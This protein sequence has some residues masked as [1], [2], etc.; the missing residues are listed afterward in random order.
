VA[1]KA[2]LAVQ[3]DVT[4]DP[5]VRRQIDWLTSAG[6]T[7]D[8]LGYGDHP[9]P[10]VREHF[11]VQRPHGWQKSY[12][13]AALAHVFLPYG[14]RFKALTQ[15]RFP[16]KVSQQVA[17]GEY[18]LVI[19]NDYHF[20]PWLHDRSVF[21][22]DRKVAHVHIDLHEYFPRDL[23]KIVTGWQL[24]RPY[25]RWVR[26]FIN[27]PLVDT[28][29]VAGA[30]AQL[31]ADE[32]GFAPPPLVRNM[33]PREDLA[34]T[35]VDPER[36]ELIHHGLGSWVRGLREMVDAMREVDS[37]FVLTFMLTGQ[38]SAMD[39]LPAYIADQSDRIRMVPPAPMRDLARTIN[40]YDVEVAFFPPV[41]QNLV[42]TLP[43]KIFEA[44]QGRLAIVTG[45]TKLMVEAV[46]EFGNGVVTAGWTPADLAAAINSLTAERITEMKLASH[47]AAEHANSEAESANFLRSVGQLA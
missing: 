2:L 23:P 35:P 7:V 13:G 21:P 33:P 27:D 14:P 17:A 19:L 44:V 12:A 11:E 34:P 42:Y 36:I 38:E 37:R 4:H 31:Y 5:R 15:S 1:K 40:A 10:E 47:R 3:T 32:F 43:N 25:H 26:Q 30:T 46:E 29:S 22:R 24:M 39:E 9:A 45:P 6:W 20:I 16:A 28:R 8:T 41:T 18:D